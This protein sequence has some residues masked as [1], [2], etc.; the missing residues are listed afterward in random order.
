MF[1]RSRSFYRA[2]F[3]VLVAMGRSVTDYRCVVL[4]VAEAERA[5]QFNLDRDYRTL[6]LAGQ[7]KKPGKVWLWLEPAPREHN[8]AKSALQ[9]VRKERAILR[10]R[11]ND[12]KVLLSK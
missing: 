12:W 8:R 3:V 4:P 6:T 10:K 7:K 1:N 9:L 5:A 2:D 11:D